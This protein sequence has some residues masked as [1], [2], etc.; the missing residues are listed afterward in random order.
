MIQPE[1][2][3]AVQLDTSGQVLY[4]FKWCKDH[5]N[6]L[7]NYSSALSFIEQRFNP[8]VWDTRFIELQ[9]PIIVEFEELFMW[10][11]VQEVTWKRDSEQNQPN[12]I[13]WENGSIWQVISY[14]EWKF[15]VDR[16]TSKIKK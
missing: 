2:I 10:A 12:R 1:P 7:D 14:N 8:E 5:T 15:C 3:F 16:I 6:W 13:E 9:K 11:T 4:F